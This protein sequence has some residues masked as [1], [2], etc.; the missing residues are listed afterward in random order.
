MTCA[1]EIWGPRNSRRCLALPVA[2]LPE[3]PTAVNGV[4]GGDG[5]G[6]RPVRSWR[7]TYKS[8]KLDNFLVGTA[9][10]RRPFVERSP[11][12]H[13]LGAAPLP[14]RVISRLTATDPRAAR[15]PL[16]D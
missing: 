4:G 9:P 16:A 5:L 6:R 14:L 8:G 1:K 3:V 10:P 15:C 2:G 12:S 7:F 11:A 13:L